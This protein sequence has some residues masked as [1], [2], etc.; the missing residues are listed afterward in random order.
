MEHV[1]SKLT[2]SDPL[3]SAGHDETVAWLKLDASE[4][5]HPNVE[6]VLNDFGT[7]NPRRKARPICSPAHTRQ[8]SAA[9]CS[10]LE[11]SRYLRGAEGSDPRRRRWQQQRSVVPRRMSGAFWSFEMFSDLPASLRAPARAERAGARSSVGCEAVEQAGTARALQRVLT[12]T[13]R[14]VRGVPGVHVPGVLRVRHGH[15]DPRWQSPRRSSSSFRRWCRRRPWRTC[16][17][18]P[19]RSEYRAR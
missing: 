9:F 4:A 10:K 11:V 13:A 12:A 8:F 5:R 7:S 19:S 18:G 16:P 6:A 15:G 2:E 1:G 14:A 3:R 17:A